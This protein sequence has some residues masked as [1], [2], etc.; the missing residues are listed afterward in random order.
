MSLVL[1]F[2]KN[3]IPE[4]TIGNSDVVRPILLKSVKIYPDS[5]CITTCRLLLKKFKFECRMFIC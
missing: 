2:K 5:F 4:D 3:E 1:L